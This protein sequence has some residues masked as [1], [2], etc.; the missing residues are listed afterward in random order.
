MGECIKELKDGG[1]ERTSG[2]Y[3]NADKIVVLKKGGVAEQGTHEGL[4]AQK[5][6]YYELVK[7]QIELG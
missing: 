5:G 7:N 4:I 6:Y 2:T 1:R 3:H